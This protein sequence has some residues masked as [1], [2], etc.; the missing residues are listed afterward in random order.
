M[1]YRNLIIVIILNLL[2]IGAGLLVIF[3]ISRQ[4]RAVNQ[5][6][7]EIATLESE[8]RGLTET[9]RLLASLR[10]DK[11]KLDNYV[12]TEQNT[13]AFLDYL[14]V[15]ARQTGVAMT[16]V[17]AGVGERLSLRLSVRGPYAT[18]I[19]YLDLLATSHYLLASNHLDLQV[20]PDGKGVWVGNVAL[21]LLSF[22]K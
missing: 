10:E 22:K 17:S 14:E 21:E 1:K 18:I 6:G 5:V 13:D 15:V 8:K 4:V 7:N 12:V 9:R 11:I 19:K 16:I 3:L 2:V 20:I